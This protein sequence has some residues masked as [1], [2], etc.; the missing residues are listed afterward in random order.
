M[1]KDTIFHD[2]VFLTDKQVFWSKKR[3][4]TLDEHELNFLLKEENVAPN[5]TVDLLKSSSATYAEVVQSSSKPKINVKIILDQI[6]D[7]LREHLPVVRLIQNNNETLYEM[8]SN[9][10][11]VKLGMAEFDTFRRWLISKSEVWRRL[12]FLLDDPSFVEVKARMDIKAICEQLY[13]RFEMDYSKTIDREPVPISWGEMPALRVLDPGTIVDGPTKAW[14]EFTERLD[15][16]KAFKAFIWSIFDIN[17]RGR[18]CC[19]IRGEGHDGKTSVAGALTRFIGRDHVAALKKEESIDR[20]FLSQFEDKRFGVFG[21]CNN[22]NLLSTGIIKSIISGEVLSV[23]HK[24]QN[25]YTKHIYAKLLIMSNYSP[26][27]NMEDRSEISRLLYLH[28]SAPKQVGGDNTFEDRLVEEMPNFLYKCREAY[29][30]ECENGNDINVPE[31]MA[32]N[33]QIFC[34]SNDSDLFANFANDCLD[35]GPEYETKLQD[36]RNA[37]A[38]YM[39]KNWSGNKV[40]FA[41]DRLEKFLKKSDVEI[42]HKRPKSGRRYRSFLGV[43]LLKA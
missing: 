12:H 6:Y 31:G 10:Q 23:E 2:I 18:Q 16:P 35:F 25:K 34:T 21:E 13:R 17:N 26:Q 40:D 3:K 20:F 41:M 30:Q 29:R 36:M 43:K 11:V 33:I 5:I 28:L 32:E 27:I 38:A 39:S 4:R 24:Y 19:W 9:N 22:R 14:D 37:L 8:G 7:Q 15:Y 42:K 1:R